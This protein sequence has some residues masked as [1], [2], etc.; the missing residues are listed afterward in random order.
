[1]DGQQ[2]ITTILEYF[3]NQFPLRG[4][5]IL[6]TLEGKTFFELPKEIRTGLARR[7]LSAV[8]L[9]KESAPSQEYSAQLRRYVFERLNTGGIRLNAQELRNS[10]N[11]GPFN[12]LL[13]ELSR[14]ELFTTLWGIPPAEPHEK[15]EP[16]AKLRNNNLYRQMRDVELVLR[17][18][19]LLNTS[20]FG[21]GMKST[22]DNAM[23]EYSKRS[24]SELLDLQVE[25]MW[26]LKLAHQIG[27]TNVF[28]L[29][30]G[31]GSR[32]R[33]SASLF[34]GIMVALMRKLTQA[35]LIDSHAAQINQAIQSALENADFHEL[36]AGRANTKDAT[37]KR[38]QHIESLIDSA[39]GA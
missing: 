17:V 4:L 2:R 7:S 29:P 28:R 8:I 20:N 10:V 24:K 3:Q 34:D 32:G 13:H 14:S 21:K 11:A 39:I 31:Q 27:N 36:V 38:A 1:M 12:D 16:S 37:L 15:T 23:D 33:L 35:S 22:L 19:A 30:T 6:G 18:F 5:E 25:F 26:A 9:L